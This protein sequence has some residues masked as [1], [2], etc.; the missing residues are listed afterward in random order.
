MNELDA[1]VLI[2]E[3][4]SRMLNGGV[5]YHLV[6]HWRGATQPPMVLQQDTRV[7]PSGQPLNL[8]ASQILQLG[9]A[10]A[11]ALGLKFFDNSH[12][13]S[14]CPVSVFGP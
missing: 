12:F 10:Y 2:S 4:N 1:V 3:P 8:A 9:L 5:T 13:A 14:P 7:L 11:H 6:L